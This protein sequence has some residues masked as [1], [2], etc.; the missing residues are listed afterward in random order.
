MKYNQIHVDTGANYAMSDNNVRKNNGN[1]FDCSVRLNTYYRNIKSISLKNVQMPLFFYN[2]RSS[3]NTFTIAGSLKTVSSGTY[4]IDNLITAMNAAAG[5]GTFAKVT[6]TNN[7]TFIGYT[8]TNGQLIS[9]PLLTLL[10][11]S[12][13][14]QTTV[15]TTQ[16]V[17]SGAL[18]FITDTYV[19]L[20]FPDLGTSSRENMPGTF[21]IPL[22]NVASGNILSWGDMNQNEQIVIM[23]DTSK[24]IDRLSV[25]V[26][27]RNGIL[28]DNNGVDWSFSIE[29]ET[30]EA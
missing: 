13:S 12:S 30:C 29:I 15:G 11:F 25:K 26:L 21:K 19:Y 9:G 23:T 8:G 17:A 22:N 27:D 2:I 1:P 10:G 14:G 3:N 6:T 4:T 5:G 24:N 20:Y 18:N 7:F 16:L 28:L